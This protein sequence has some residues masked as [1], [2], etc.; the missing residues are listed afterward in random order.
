MDNIKILAAESLGVRALC[1]LVEKDEQRILIDPGISLGYTRQGL[2]P[3][4]IQIAA[5]E[6]IRK[7]IIK[8][9][10]EASDLVISH[11]HGDHI[12]FAEANVYQI[13]LSEVKEYLKGINIWSKSAEDESHKFQE[14]AWNLKFN[15][16]KFTAVEGES[17]GDIS[18]SKPVFHGEK[19][20]FL[21]RVM[22][23]KIK[24]QDKVFVHASDIQFLYRPT[25]KKLIKMKPDLVVASGP[26][27]YLSHVDQ[28]MAAE[29]AEN[30]L[31]L[32]SV[33][34]TLIIDHHLLRSEGG[35]T[36]LRKLNDKSQNQII[37]AADFMGIKP[38]L[39]EARRE[40][41]Y[42][43]FSVPAGWHKKYEAGQVDTIDY[44][45]KARE[46]LADFGEFYKFISD[47]EK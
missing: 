35:L 17:F 25:I 11:F 2:L 22:M 30:I 38:C 41:L 27:L 19:D 10:K 13:K 23:T 26:P 7:N 39:L 12:P 34:E 6:I 28:K 14:R 18:F 16:T 36:Y 8:E 5:D 33:V 29:A 40:E 43:R 44:L 15:S 37:S 9:L 20:S 3:H 45:L 1:C 47:L 32:S 46:K 21:G 4:P 24:L 42:D 31:L